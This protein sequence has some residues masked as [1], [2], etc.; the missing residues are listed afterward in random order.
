MFAIN[1]RKAL[2]ANMVYSSFMVFQ[3]AKSDYE[4]NLVRNEDSDE[5]SINFSS[6]DVVKFSISFSVNIYPIVLYFFFLKV[7]FKITFKS[8]N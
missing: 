1:I 6:S 8:F 4:E 2:L 7:F 3:N 5:I